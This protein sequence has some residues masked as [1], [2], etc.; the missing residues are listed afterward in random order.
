MLIAWSI[1]STGYPVQS[2]ESFVVSIA[3]L[4]LTLL[5]NAPL[6]VSKAVINKI[7]YRYPRWVIKDGPDK[8]I[9]RLMRPAFTEDISDVGSRLD[10]VERHASLRANISDKMK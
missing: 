10:V 6:R 2:G 9:R 8:R 4:D 7:D 3:S 5:F 1:G